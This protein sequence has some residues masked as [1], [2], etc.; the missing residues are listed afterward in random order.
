VLRVVLGLLVVSLVVLTATGVYLWFRYLPTAASAW[1]GVGTAHR[2]SG[3]ASWTRT[4]HRI[5]GIVTLVLASAALVVMVG[6]RVSTRSRGIVAGAALFATSLASLGTGFLLPWDQ[7]ALWA[8]SVGN[9]VR[10]VSA[11]FR[12]EVKYVIIGTREVSPGTYRFWAISHVVLAVL[13]AAS[14]LLAWLRTRRP[15]VVVSPTTQNEVLSSS[16]R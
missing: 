5:I 10:G 7:L 11:T 14:V 4:T 2:T 9:D 12:G 13:V 3:W 1:P 16:R 8:V 15:V 6:R